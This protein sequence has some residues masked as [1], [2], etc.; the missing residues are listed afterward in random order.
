MI[1]EQEKYYERKNREAEDL[2]QL[3][4][5]VAIVAVPVFLLWVAWPVFLVCA[6]IALVYFVVKM[7]LT[8]FQDI[9]NVIV[10]YCKS[11]FIYNT[12]HKM[13]SWI[14][15]DWQIVFDFIGISILLAFI[16]NTIIININTL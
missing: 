7:V 13:C 10:N 1:T 3:M 4:V 12:L 5:I 15:I 8:T 2:G 16:I 14:K 9:Y 6:I 11:T